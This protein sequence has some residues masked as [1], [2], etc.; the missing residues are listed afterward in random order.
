MIFHR[1]RLPIDCLDTLVIWGLTGLV[2]FS[3]ALQFS[4]HEL[5]CPLCLLQRMGSLVMALSL[6]LTL[7]FGHRTRHYGLTLIASIFTG[8]VASR[9]TLLHIIPGTDTYGDPFLG[10]SLYVWMVIVC[11]LVVSYITAMLVIGANNEKRLQPAKFAKITTLL[12]LAVIFI[13][14]A[15]V[16][17][18]CGLQGCP[19]NPT[20]YHMHPLRIY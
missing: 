18:E 7:Q 8:I 13:A 9:Q 14:T 1:F 19:E 4:T 5:P 16:F 11:L 20:Q 3:L 6:A 15:M 2:I 17:F 10:L 12:V